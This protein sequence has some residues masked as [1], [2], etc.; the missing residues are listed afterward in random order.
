MIVTYEAI[1]ELM[2]RRRFE[3]LRMAAFVL[4]IDRVANTYAAA[5]I[6]P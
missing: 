1:F 6:F 3:D 4:A 5:G 2:A